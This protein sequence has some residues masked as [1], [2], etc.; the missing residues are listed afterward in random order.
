MNFILKNV[1]NLVGSFVW[2]A[3]TLWITEE[4]G[5]LCNIV[6]PILDPT[7]CLSHLISSFCAIVKLYSVFL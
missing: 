7:V 2:I 1:F 4:N 3:F 6:S 5:H